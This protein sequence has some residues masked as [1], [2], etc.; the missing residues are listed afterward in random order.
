[1]PFDL[2]IEIRNCEGLGKLDA[3][4]GFDSRDD[5][6]RGGSEIWAATMVV[7]FEFLSMCGSPMRALAFA[8]SSALR[9]PDEPDGEA[10]ARSAD[11]PAS[12]DPGLRPR[13]RLSPATPIAR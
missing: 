5:V 4:V 7:E 8:N 13:L 2:A 9:A 12:F 10:G 6:V 1:M 3:A 11:E